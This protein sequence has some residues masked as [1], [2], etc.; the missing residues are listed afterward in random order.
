MGK[1]WRQSKAQ[2]GGITLQAPFVCLL[3]MI[4]M[5]AHLLIIIVQSTDVSVSD[6]TFFTLSSLSKTALLPVIKGVSSPVILISEYVIDLK[7]NRHRYNLVLRDKKK[8]EG[9]KIT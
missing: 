7:L 5:C 8:T 6:V 2:S 4:K 1:H 9:I 3:P